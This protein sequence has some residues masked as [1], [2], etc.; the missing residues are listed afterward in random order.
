MVTLSIPLSPEAEC[1]LR[2]R[3]QASGKDPAIVAAEL[4]NHM[5]T[6]APALSRDRLREISGP[7][8][9]AFLKSGATDEQLADELE[10]IKHAHRS[11]LRGTSF[12]E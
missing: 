11:T 2:Q 6:A 1:A 4:L 5:L 9:D 3:A 8:Y 12:N 10:D 7:S